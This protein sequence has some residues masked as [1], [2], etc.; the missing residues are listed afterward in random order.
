VR[1]HVH[2]ENTAGRLQ[3]ARDFRERP[4]RLRHVMQDEHQRRRVQPLFVDRQ[5][6]E[7][8]PPQVDVVQPLQT[9][10]RRLQHGR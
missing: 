7:F 9:F 6:L 4:V 8:A 10:A 1:Q 2:E 5:C 3:H